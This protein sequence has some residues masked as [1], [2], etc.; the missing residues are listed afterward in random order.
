MMKLNDRFYNLA[1]KELLNDSRSN[2]SIAEVRYRV[3]KLLYAEHRRTVR[4]VKA[5]QKEYINSQDT[6]VMAFDELLT[7]LA[8]KRGR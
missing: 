2:L 8:R 1:D 3:V 7:K 5:L 6:P 4:M